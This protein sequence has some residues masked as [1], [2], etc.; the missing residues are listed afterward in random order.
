MLYC[1]FYLENAKKRSSPPNS[2]DIHVV[3]WH[4]GK[5]GE[6]KCNLCKR[7]GNSAHYSQNLK[8]CDLGFPSATAQSSLTVKCFFLL[9]SIKHKVLATCCNCC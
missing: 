4:N 3:S 5:F 2:Q 9:Q 8:G 1:Y 7:N 6:M